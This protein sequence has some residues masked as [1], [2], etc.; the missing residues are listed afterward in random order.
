MLSSVGNDGVRDFLHIK[1]HISQ[2]NL[3]RLDNKLI[4]FVWGILTMQMGNLKFLV[5]QDV[6]LLDELHINAHFRY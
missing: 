1:G 2:N 6:L 4:P 5:D 3:H